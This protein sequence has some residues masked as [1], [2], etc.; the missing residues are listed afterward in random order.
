MMTSCLNLWLEKLEMMNYVIIGIRAA[1]E[2]ISNSG[3]ET[4]HHPPHPNEKSNVFLCG[5]VTPIKML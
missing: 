5:Y 4:S 2:K 1:K 3:C